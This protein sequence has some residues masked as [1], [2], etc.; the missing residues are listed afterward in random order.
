MLNWSHYYFLS[1]SN[2]NITARQGPKLV[3]I[4]N[5]LKWASFLAMT[6]VFYG[7]HRAMPAETAMAPKLF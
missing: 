4:A 5:W 3:K 2:K 1:F 7:K 6:P